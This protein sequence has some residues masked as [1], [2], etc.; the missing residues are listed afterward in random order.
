MFIKT[1]LLV[2]SSKDIYRNYFK[3]IPRQNF[4]LFLPAVHLWPLMFISKSIQL[5]AFYRGK[6]NLKVTKL[7]IITDHLKQEKYH[8]VLINIFKQTLFKAQCHLFLVSLWKAK[9]D[10]CFNENKMLTTAILG[11]RN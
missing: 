10:I 2:D 6:E 3:F 11:H 4:I 8:D 7:Y 5:I 1:Y 9:K